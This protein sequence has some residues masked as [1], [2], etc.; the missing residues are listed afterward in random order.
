MMP[1]YVEDQFIAA[2]KR[3]GLRVEPRADGLWRVEHVLADLRSE[4]LASV[5]KLGKA[6]NEYRKITFQKDVLEQDQHLDAVLLG[7]GHALYAAV[8]EKLNESLAPAVGGT[9]IF[10]DPE[11]IAPYRMHFFEISIKGKDSHGGDVSLYAEVVAVREES[12]QREIV[13]ADVLIDLV[14]H[15][16]QPAEPASVDPQAAADFLKSS[17]QVEVRQLEFP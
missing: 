3:I 8:D 4:R 17:Y 16:H 9:A 13:P 14:P 10:M 12:D 11:A 5:Q 15:P 1:K 7:P 6:N 2:S